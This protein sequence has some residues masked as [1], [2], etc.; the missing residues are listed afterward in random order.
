[1]PNPNFYLFTGENEYALSQEILRWKENFRTKHGAENLVQLHG[2]SQSLSELLDAVSVLPF[3]AEKRLVLCDGIPKV[4]KQQLL[5]VLEAIHHQTV[6]VVYSSKIDKR[7]SVTKELQA[8]AGETKDFKP[9]PPAQLQTWMKEFLA[10]RGAVAQPAALSLLLRIVGTDQWTLSNE[11]SKLAAYSST[12]G[13]EQVEL[14][15]V[16]SGAQVIWRLTDLVGNRKTNEALKFFNDQVE[17][18]EDAYGMWAVL[19]NMVK[20]LAAVWVCVQSGVQSDKAIMDATGVHF[21]GVRGLM[22]LVKS[23]DLRRVRWLVNWAADADTELKTGGFK[24]TAEHT[25]ELSALADRIIV[26]CA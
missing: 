20:N 1:M 2:P 24:Y 3:I 10:S 21:L 5:T 22:P 25:V 23:L 4:D 11:L 7:L 9:L 8:Q 17:R 13:V 26:A 14:L 19:L 12:I 15:A 18:G 6:F 16:P